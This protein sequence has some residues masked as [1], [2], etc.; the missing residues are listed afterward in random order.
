MKAWKI[1]AQDPSETYSDEIWVPGQFRESE[2]VKCPLINDAHDRWYMFEPGEEVKVSTFPEMAAQFDAGQTITFSQLNFE[3]ADVKPALSSS[4]EGA[5]DSFE[6]V[7][8]YTY[9]TEWGEESTASYPESILVPEGSP[10]GDRTAVTALCMAPDLSDIEGREYTH[11]ILYRT[12][13]GQGT[14]TFYR[15]AEYDLQS[16]GGWGT[17]VS[18]EDNEFSSITVL[19][20]TLNSQDNEQPPS[21]LYGAKVHSS[22][23]MVAFNGRD[24]YFSKPFLPHAWPAEYQKA[25]PDTIVGIE[26]YEQNIAVMTDGRPSVLYGSDPANI[27]LLKF[28]FPEPCVAYGSIVASPEGAYYASHQGL[29]LLTTVGPNNVTKALLSAEEWQ[30]QYID[31]GAGD[32][33]VE[34]SAARYETQY[35]ATQTGGAGFLIDNLDPR[36][37]LNDW[38]MYYSLPNISTLMN[39]MYTGQIYALSQSD[40]SIFLWDSY[41]ANEMRYAWRSKQ[42]VFPKPVNFGSLEVHLEPVQ[43]PDDSSGDMGGV[44]PDEIDNIDHGNE[45]LVE[46][47]ANDK[48]VW[49][50]GV[51]DRNPVRLVVGYKADTWEIAI[52]GECRVYSVAMTE[53][54]R[55]QSSV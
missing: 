14:S 44:W 7:Y 25:V 39:D 24:V 23:A 6:R 12:V 11:I 26:P 31:D 20:D 9:I 10:P 53:T 46:V 47:Y 19:N 38:D 5:D 33:S 27:G 40:R 28:S 29:V 34:M 37:A 54:G 22:G 45:V 42:Q 55:G 49:V 21:G 13:D 1:R 2:L 51:G 52:Y 41:S 4:D 36:V 30:S 50:G 43:Y 8:L 17:Q 48:R 3:H 16:S 32:I 15:C 35:I 18:I